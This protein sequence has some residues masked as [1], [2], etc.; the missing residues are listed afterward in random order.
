[1]NETK[2]DKGGNQCGGKAPQRHGALL[3]DYIAI[4]MRAVKL[5][6]IE[7]MAGQSIL[8][9]SSGFLGDFQLAHMEFCRHTAV[10]FQRFGVFGLVVI[11]TGIAS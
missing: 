1:M 11:V 4:Q 6:D 3:V 5:V 7:Y 9:E 2:A 8:D 10:G